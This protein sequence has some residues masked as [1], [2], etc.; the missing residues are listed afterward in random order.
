MSEPFTR[1]RQRPASRIRRTTGGGTGGRPRSGICR[2]CGPWGGRKDAGKRRP[3]HPL[4]T[5]RPAPRGGRTALRCAQRQDQ[6]VRNDRRADLEPTAEHFEIVRPLRRNRSSC[7]ASVP[8]PRA[9]LPCEGPFEAALA[10][11]LSGDCVTAVDSQ[12]FTGDERRPLRSEEASGGADVGWDAEPS[13]G[14]LLGVALEFWT[15]TSMGPRDWVTC[16]TKVKR[17]SSSVTSAGKASAVPPAS[18]M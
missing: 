3:Y 12:A 6:Q 18:R 5:R 4:N 16:W 15:A 7:G 10:G 13:Q 17:L 11:V 2:L 9:L 8:I 14:N 1:S